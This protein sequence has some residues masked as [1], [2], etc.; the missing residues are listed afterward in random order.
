MLQQK[1]LIVIVVYVVMTDKIYYVLTENPY[2]ILETDSINDLLTIL[3]EG[4]SNFISQGQVI[5]LGLPKDYLTILRKK[6]SQNHV[7]VPL[8]DIVSD[9]IFLIHW[10]KVYVR[11]FFDNYRFVDEHFYHDLEKLV[12]PTDVDKENLRLLSFFDMPSLQK[13]YLEIFYKS[14]V[15][16][17]YITNCRR[18]SFYSGMEH[19]SPYYNINELNYLAYDWGISDKITLNPKEINKLCEKISQYDIPAK[20]LLDHQIYIYDSKAIGLVKHYSLFGSYYMNL[21]LRSNNCC[22][23]NKKSYQGII[24]NPYLENQIEIMINLIKN[25]PAFQKSHTVYRFVERDDYFNNIKVGDVY[26]DSSFMSTTRNPF[27]YKENYAFGYILI[28]INIPAD[29]KGVG[30]C[31]ESYSNFPKEE[32]IILPPASQ[33]RLDNLIEEST[34]TDFHNAFDLQVKKKYEFTWIGNDNATLE[35][36]G[37]TIPEN[38]LVVLSELIN[39]V[40]IKYLSISDRLRYFRQN[41]TNVNNQ[42]ESVIAGTKYTFNLESYDSSSVYK[43]FFYYEVSDGIMIT[44]ANPKYG[45]INILMEIG[46][47]IHVNYYFRFSVTDPSFVVDLDKKEW[48]EWLSYLAYV[49]GSQSV[50]IHSNYILQYDPKDSIE[51]KLLKTRYTFSENIYLY[52]K[53]GKKMFQYFEVTSFDYLKIDYLRNVDLFDH[54]KSTDRN[55]LFRI[56]QSS[57]CKNIFDFYL[58]IVEN[59][60]KQINILEDK[61][62]DVYYPNPNPFKHVEYKLNAWQYLYSHDIIR[63]IPDEKNFNIKRGSF[64]KLIGEKKIKKFTN[65][66]RSLINTV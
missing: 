42:F 58:Y 62:D 43:K 15:V 12:S 44:T 51:E 5:E 4:N 34:N 61:L 11:I 14:F 41:F 25:A 23:P 53:Y 30:L 9:H 49:I 29:I 48:M 1:I 63:Q 10:D 38:K 47:E 20:T 8:Y 36:P 28:K 37:A 39:D 7:R 60:P 18:P 13:T 27:Y 35:M 26:Y 54:I 46:P 55:E 21:Y 2:N 6:I 45:N 65:R 24:R 17:S 22:F 52:M 50:V 56:A 16:N 3:Y 32:E 59:F 64:K 33:Y 66:L 19:I 40:N 57:D 31:I